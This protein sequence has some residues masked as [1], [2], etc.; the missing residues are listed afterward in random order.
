MMKNVF[1]NRNSL[2][3]ALI[4]LFISCKSDGQ[5]IHSFPILK[6]ES[7]NLGT[8]LLKEELDLN[9][10]IQESDLILK[11]EVK[12]SIME[13]M[14]LPRDDFYNYLTLNFRHIN[15]ISVGNRFIVAEKGAEVFFDYSSNMR[16]LSLCIEI[17]NGEIKK[18][19]L[20]NF[21]APTDYIRSTYKIKSDEFILLDRNIDVE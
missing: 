14:Y 4:F 15:G 20:P 10:F 21:I 8:I 17:P 19:T 2:L 3:L 5:E 6:L 7:Q 12:D 18:D 16:G 13:I 1:I 9:Q 11:Y